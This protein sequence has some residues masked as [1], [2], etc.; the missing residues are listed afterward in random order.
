MIAVIDVDN[1]LWRF[2]AV[3][4]MEL[5]QLNPNS[6]IPHE[7]DDWEEPL[8]YCDSEEQFLEICNKIS[9]NHLKYCPFFEAKK[10]LQTLKKNGYEICIAT[11][12]NPKTGAILI[13]WLNKHNLLYDSLYMGKDKT[14]LFNNPK[15][16]LVI[17]DCPEI[18]QKTF[19]IPHDIK[20]MGLKYKYNERML[21]FG[22]SLY[23][24]SSDLLKGVEDYVSCY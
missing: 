11:H 15:I 7:W 19:N 3:L 18:Q 20:V 8:D 24:N 22:V 2:D 1:T 13:K 21:F 9:L 12:R 17:D 16:K 10:I 14:I 23:K 5:Y 4:R 6:I